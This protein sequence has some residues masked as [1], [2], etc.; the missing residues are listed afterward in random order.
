VGTKLDEDSPLLEGAA[1]YERDGYAVAKR[2]QERIV[3]E[4]CQQMG[5]D[6]RV[7][8]PGFIWG[9][10]AEWIDGIGHR[11][12]RFIFVVG[13]TAR[14]PLTHVNNA[15]DAF[16]HI[17]AED[18]AAGQTY[19]LVD[20]HGTRSWR[21]AGD[22]VKRH[23]G[24]RIPMPYACGRFIAAAAQAVS[25]RLFGPGAK[26]PGLFVPIKFQAR[27]KPVRCTAAKLR[28][29]LDWKPPLS[30]EDAI[31]ATYRP[32]AEPAGPVAAASHST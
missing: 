15:A 28:Y 18:R 23:G 29:Q 19:N 30:Y 22:Y 27:F 17:T 26:L 13:P 6:L 9:R 1:T 10:G 11:F 31:A 8:R 25:R 21:F 4:K 2:W 3:R 12:G 7:I 20:N 16:A 14:P 32:S 24:M 5:W